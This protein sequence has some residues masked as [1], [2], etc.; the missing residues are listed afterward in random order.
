MAPKKD[1]MAYNTNALLT[2]H[3]EQR[4]VSLGRWTWFVNSSRATVVAAL[5][6]EID[7][8]YGIVFMIPSWSGGPRIGT[9]FGSVDAEL[10]DAR[11]HQGR[12]P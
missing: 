8:G 6:V 11:W 4:L 2:L 3:P 9:H 10:D 12:P 7:L 1:D 5:F